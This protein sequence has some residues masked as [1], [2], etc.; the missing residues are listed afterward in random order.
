MDKSIY[1]KCITDLSYIQAVSTRMLHVAA[2]AYEQS[3]SVLLAWYAC[4]TAAACQS[5]TWLAVFP[6]V[7]PL[8]VIYSCHP[9]DHY[10]Y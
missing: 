7:G 8:L 1:Y 2:V 4:H 6:S 3:V 9:A 10:D 5:Y